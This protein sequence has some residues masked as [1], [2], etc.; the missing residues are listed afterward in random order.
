[1]LATPPPG[2]NVGQLELEGQPIQDPVGAI[3]GQLRTSMLNVATAVRL[4]GR[5]KMTYFGT[6]LPP[7]QRFTSPSQ[8]NEPNEVRAA[9]AQAGVAPRALNKTASSG[10]R[11]AREL[12]TMGPVLTRPRGAS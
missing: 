4:G 8:P 3:V 9:V 5:G 11:I 7:L 2:A 12:P 1:M 10:P 6:V